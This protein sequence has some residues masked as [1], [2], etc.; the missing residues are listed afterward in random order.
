MVSDFVFLRIVYMC[1]HV[2]YFLYFF[3][4]VLFFFACFSKESESEKEGI[5]LD[6]G[7]REDLGGYEGEAMTGI[8]CIN[9]KFQSKKVLFQILDRCLICND[10][11]HPCSERMS[12]KSVQN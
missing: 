12:S 10:R 11:Y 4:F 9:I 6:G 5:E 7:G 2:M 8:Y 3:C 1:V